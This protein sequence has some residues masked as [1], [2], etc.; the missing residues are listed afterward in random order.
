MVSHWTAFSETW[1]SCSITGR[2]VTIIVWLARLTKA[3]S[4]RIAVINR[5]VRGVMVVGDCDTVASSFLVLNY[6]SNFTT[7]IL[8]FL[9]EIIS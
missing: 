8:T 1:S 6:P 9:M 3:D 7:A 2:A 5:R 4:K